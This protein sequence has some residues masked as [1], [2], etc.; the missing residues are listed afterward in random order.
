MTTWNELAGTTWSGEGEL[1][2]DPLGYETKKCACT[3]AVETEALRYTWS[4]EDS[5]Q[6][7]ELV[8]REGGLEF[9]D[10]WHSPTPMAFTDVPGGW[11]LLNARGTYGAGAHG[12]PDWGWRIVLSLRSAPQPTLVLQMT[13]VAPWGEE[14]RAVRMICKRVAD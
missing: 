13:N 11:G 2:L 14:A 5:P 4:Y 1:W 9:T 6:N 7:G 10:T 12:G 3:I 8:L